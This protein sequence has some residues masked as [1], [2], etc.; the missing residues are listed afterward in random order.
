[1]LVEGFERNHLQMIKS[2]KG[3]PG[4]IPE[5]YEQAVKAVR[6]CALSLVGEPIIYPKINDFLDMLHAKGISS[7]MV[8]NAQFPDQM[9][10]LHPCTQLYISIDAPTKDELKAV[11]RPLFS[12]FWE[13]F[14]TCIKMLREKKQRTV[15]RL[16]LVDGWNTSELD[17]YAE[18]VRQGQPDFI[19]I[20][21]VTYCGDS[22]ASPLTIKNCPFHEQV[23]EYC[24]R[25]VAAVDGYLLASEHA[26]SNCVLLAKDSFLIDGQW[27]TWIDYDRFAELA[28]SGKP[29]TSTDY[30]APTPSWAVYTPGSVDG[31]FDPNETHVAGKGKTKGA[32]C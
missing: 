25:L 19:E 11:D 20:K 24:Q 1:M 32:G 3:V 14:I 26:H 15:F 30:M 27:H 2:L 18:L 17:A 8:T 31:G 4:V 23:V 16:T 9:E 13:R 10:T 29:F 28:T 22:K 6:H 5:R 21:G 12:D 7:F